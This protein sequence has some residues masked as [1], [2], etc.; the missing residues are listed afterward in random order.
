MLRKVKSSL[1]QK[2]Q[3]MKSPEVLVGFCA[4]EI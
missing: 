1:P 2:H 3:N 4:F